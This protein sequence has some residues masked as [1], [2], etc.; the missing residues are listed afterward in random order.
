MR[1]P[2]GIARVISGAGSVAICSHINPDGDT[3]GSALAMRLVLEYLGKKADC[4][5][6]DKVPDN[7]KFLPGADNILTPEQAAEHYDLLLSV[8][9]SDPARF[10][11]CWDILRGRCDHFAQIDHHGTNP[12][13]A[14]VNSVDG[15]ASATCVMIRE[16]MKYLKVPLSRDI[17]ICLYAGISTDTGNFSFNCTNAETFRAM[18]DIMETEI[19]ISRLSSILFRERTRSQLK[20][21]GRAIGSVEYRGKDEDIAVMRLYLKDFED[22][23]ALMEHADD[24]VNFALET[25]DTEM[26]LMVKEDEKGKIKCSLRA[27]PPYFVDEA[28]NRLGGGGHPQAAGIAMEGSLD[29][30]LEKVVSEMEKELERQ[31]AMKL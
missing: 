8:D 10:G 25:T 26:A 11:S 18:A 13:F 15:D 23:G 19:P 16:Q 21:L 4:F 3:I 12:L 17:S 20:L 7:L 24:V 28:A 30:C 22:C 14:E 5:C 2:E 1:D 31:K 29:S 27:E 6:Q 9:I